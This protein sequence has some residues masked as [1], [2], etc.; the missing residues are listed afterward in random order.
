FNQFLEK[1][2]EQTLKAF[3][4]QEFQF[5]ELVEK[6]EINR[7]ASRNPV[8]DVM[9]SL[10]SRDALPGERAPEDPT[11]GKTGK[12]SQ[13]A[14][15]V[16]QYAAPVV[17]YAEPGEQYRY[18]NSIAKFDLTLDIL[19]DAGSEQLICSFEYCSELFDKETISGFI[20]RFK[21]IIASVCNNREQAI[22]EIEILSEE[23][24]I[25]LLYDFND[26][27]SEY[28]KDKTLHQLFEEQ[29]ERTPDNSLLVVCGSGKSGMGTREAAAT[30]TFSYKEIN[31]EANHLARELRQGGVT[32]DTIVGIMV[33][34]SI[35]MITGML[36][37]LKAGG[38]YLPLD[39]AYP[40][41]RIRYIL[42]ESAVKTLLAPRDLIAENQF[43]GKV[44]DPFELSYEGEAEKPANV[45]TP[46]HLA[47][48]IYT[49]GS[50][51]KPKGSAVEHGNVV[52]YLN[53]FYR[54]VTV[55][56]KNIMLQ[57]A[58]YSFD[59][60]VEEVYSIMLKGGKI[61]IPDK[62]DV[63]DVKFLARLID[64]TVVDI[65]DCSPLLLN[66][67][68]KLPAALKVKTF[69]SGGDVL[70]TEYVDNLVT[71]AKVYNS[72]G[73]TE[74]TVC[75]TY[76]DYNGQDV[77]NIPIGKPLHNYNVFILD[78]YRSLVPVGAAGEL[79][80]SG[81]GVTRG[82]LNK[83]GL[84]AEK[85]VPNPFNNEHQQKEKHLT[86]TQNSQYPN[87]Q[88]PITNNHDNLLYRTGDLARWLPDGSGNIEFLGRV[89]SQVKVRGYRIELGEIE[90]RLTEHENIKESIVLL[91]EG[92][93]GDKY[94]CAYLKLIETSVNAF[95]HAPAKVRIY[96]SGTL[97]QYMIPAVFIP[98]YKIPVTPNGKID[99]NALPLPEEWG[100]G[101]KYVAPANELE[102][103]IT[104]IWGQV[105]NLE[106]EKISTET[107]FFLLGG[108]SLKAAVMVTHLEKEMNVDVPI[109]EI[110]KR[111][112]I[113]EIANYIMQVGI[114][115]QTVKDDNLVYLR[116][117]ESSDK[118]LFLIHDGSGDVDKYIAFCK[119][120]N[121][122]FSY[123]GLQADRLENYAPGHLEV[124]EIATHYL[125]KIKKIQPEGPYYIAGWSLGGVIAYEMVTQLE[126]RNE[127]IAFLGLIDTQQP[128]MAAKLKISRFS[129]RGELRIIELLL[130][131]EFAINK[132]MKNVKPLERFWPAL[133][134]LLE[135]NNYNMNFFRDAIR[136]TLGL[137]E[138]QQTRRW[139]LRDAVYYLNM[140]R[141]MGNAARAYIPKDKINT[142][143]HFFKATQSVHL[144][145]AR[146]NK[147]TAK[148][149]KN[150][151]IIGDHFS[152]LRPP[153]VAELVNAFN[154]ALTNPGTPQS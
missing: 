85:F 118:N 4:N 110:F 128:S 18:E 145:E 126:E 119:R 82:Y 140:F 36:A 71:T 96:L 15:P 98:I 60:F 142:Q 99:V 141:T 84:T 97:P 146:W 121:S 77:A 87:N 124:K 153:Y 67:L 27:Q 149:I 2:K 49:S 39:T 123:W 6:L 22:S 72:Y 88:S 143:L 95:G 147:Y 133:I 68:N 66:Q 42:K 150:Y 115:T 53:A 76:Y 20:G 7:D 11:A 48:V 69:I 35:K 5:E 111:A 74:S 135:K 83:P 31:R 58:S 137:Q 75:I 78:K 136:K 154:D 151:D 33:T 45:N 61:V 46:E 47:Y 79:C 9:F 63:L 134:E 107:S 112:T 41:N 91:R 17:Q 114:G 16:V 55:T 73:P 38:A 52:A 94:L 21:R 92:K 32:P 103:R 10:Q 129:I 65:I 51:G 23:E 26:N 34:P 43:D 29:V 108:H 13:Y 93:D 120:M 1:V 116:K 148:P 122:D 14:A 127:V 109:V 28:P 12:E 8:F 57:Q 117:S 3:E 105:L 139:T 130:A 81:P 90:K 40:E 144:K 37:V 19:E 56:G 25:Q 104:R 102:K 24:K 54:Q 132:E 30:A 100:L 64:K 101:E 62:Y 113:K 89:D 50:T 138:I 131:G 86:G 152:I 80:V 44:I 70:K 59:A 106:E 125:D